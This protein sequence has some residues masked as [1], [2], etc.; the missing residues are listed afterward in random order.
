MGQIL[1]RFLRIAKSYSDD[2]NSSANLHYNE[3]DEELRRIIDELN[4]EYANKQHERKT[5]SAGPKHKQQAPPPPPSQNDI[6]TL[7]RACELLK[8]TTGASFE[9]IQHNHD[10]YIPCAV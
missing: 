10:G 3:K 4:G 2:S 5:R 1:N 9:D 8:V 7:S 6:M